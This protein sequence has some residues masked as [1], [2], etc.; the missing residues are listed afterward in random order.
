M[1]SCFI[2]VNI[3]RE[4]YQKAMK[5][6]RKFISAVL[7][8]IGAVCLAAAVVL[9]IRQMVDDKNSQDT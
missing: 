9:V 2:I 1:I 8:G 5:I 6:T 4:F 3:R 7:A